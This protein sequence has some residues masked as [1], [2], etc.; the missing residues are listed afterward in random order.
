[1]SLKSINL[2]APP[3]AGFLLGPTTGQFGYSEA[4]ITA[5][6]PLLNV[7]LLDRYPQQKA[8]E[9]ASALGTK[10]A[11]DVVV[12]AVAAAYFQVVAS[13]ARVETAKAALDSARETRH[14]GYRPVQ[15]R[16]LP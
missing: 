13:H 3:Q 9:T 11:R 1:L 7:A 2:K 12:Y 10:D 8:L 15:V 14:T 16:S 5:E 6:S 4:R